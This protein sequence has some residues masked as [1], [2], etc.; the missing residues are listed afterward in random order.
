[1][2]TH[3][4]T[5][6]LNVDKGN[7]SASHQK[8]CMARYIYRKSISQSLTPSSIKTTSQKKKRTWGQWFEDRFGESYNSYISRMKDKKN[9]K[10]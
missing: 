4:D 3:K 2:N 1:M 8:Y 7:M 10:S 9:G 6:P 5:L